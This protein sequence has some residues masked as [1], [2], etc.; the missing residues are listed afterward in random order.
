M[1]SWCRR[2]CADS[3]RSSSNGCKTMQRDT[4][5]KS[6]QHKAKRLVTS[7]ETAHKH[8]TNTSARAS[9]ER[10]PR[11][12]QWMVQTNG[13]FVRAVSFRTWCSANGSIQLHPLQF[14]CADGCGIIQMRQFWNAIYCECR[15]QY[16][17]NALEQIH[18]KRCK[19]FARRQMAGLV[20]WWSINVSENEGKWRACTY[21]HD[22]TCTVVTALVLSHFHFGQNDEHGE[23]T[24]HKSLA[25]STIQQN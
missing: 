18:R 9:I 25:T 11:E 19:V 13:R 6:D 23:C 15:Q 1:C 20:K 8:C 7:F 24:E 21:R 10:Q 22:T 2:W 3:R 16:K 12:Q 17:R 5:T 14:G 4:N